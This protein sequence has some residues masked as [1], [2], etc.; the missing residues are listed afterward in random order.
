MDVASCCYICLEGEDLMSPG[1]CHCRGSLGIHRACLER[2]Q[3]YTMSCGVCKARYSSL[4][5]GLHRERT[6]NG[7][8]IVYSVENGRRHGK[9][10]EFDG[11]GTL[12]KCV[13]YYDGLLDGPYHIYHEDGETLMVECMYK[14]GK[15]EGPF[16]EY[17][18][19]AN[20]ISRR[21]YRDGMCD[22]VCC[23]YYDGAGSNLFQEY[24][25]VA[26]VRDGEFKEYA[27][28]GRMTS[29]CMY[30]NGVMIAMEMGSVE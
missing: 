19:D 20:L 27:E 1:P 3:T 9:F 17:D 18:E 12:L 16:R 21:D 8:Q 26:G 13:Y 30:A 4:W 23:E 22:G 24:R 11:D 5:D 28:D 7:N 14:Q 6:L 10:E 15:K 29:R 25:M 2:V